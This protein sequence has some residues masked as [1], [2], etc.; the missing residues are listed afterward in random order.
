MFKFADG[1]TLRLRNMNVMLT[2]GIHSI[3]QLL[4]A[5]SM[6]ELDEP[7]GDELVADCRAPYA[8]EAL[9]HL[10]NMRYGNWRYERGY[11]LTDDGRRTLELF[12]LFN[13]FYE[14]MKFM[15]GKRTCTCLLHGFAAVCNTRNWF[16]GEYKSLDE[17]RLNAVLAG[18]GNWLEHDFADSVCS[19]MEN[20]QVRRSCWCCDSLTKMALAS[21]V[22]GESL[23]DL[24]PR[25]VRFS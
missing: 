8:V 10:R 4:A 5:N 24:K 20:L 21:K 14:A 3:S 19:F 15:L 2:A 25:N 22:F 18:H 11:M 16:D 7:V 9:A 12:K 6:L 23:R 1:D 17:A 13:S